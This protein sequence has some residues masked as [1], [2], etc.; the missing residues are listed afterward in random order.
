MR[1]RGYHPSAGGTWGSG[2]V[3]LR[4]TGFWFANADATELA[5][6]WVGVAEGSGVGGVGRPLL[7]P[8]SLSSLE[9]TRGPGKNGK[10]PV[11]PP[12]PSCSILLHL[13]G[14]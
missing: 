3:E 10:T 9:A 6:K 8:L 5:V 2:W 11:N 12:K 13:M 7:L 1:S 4:P 14:S